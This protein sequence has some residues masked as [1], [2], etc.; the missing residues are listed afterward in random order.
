MAGTPCP[1]LLEQASKTSLRLK[2]CA[3]CKTLQEPAKLELKIPKALWEISF[4]LRG[5]S[6]RKTVN[7]NMKIVLRVCAHIHCVSSFQCFP[8]VPALCVGIT[9]SA[10]QVRKC[11]Q[12]QDARVTW[13][14]H[15]L[16]QTH[17]WFSKLIESWC[18]SFSN[19]VWNIFLSHIST[20]AII[21]L[22]LHYSGTDLESHSQ[23]HI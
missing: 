11:S 3:I 22:F 21:Y 17:K 7:M 18:K 8:S 2:A 23:A 13:V 10:L 16:I 4:P 20:S 6:L 1:R 14:V 12:F 19:F 5:L 9:F 15:W